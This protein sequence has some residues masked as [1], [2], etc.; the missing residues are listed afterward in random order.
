MK[1]KFVEDSIVQASDG[2]RQSLE[3]FGQ[4]IEELYKYPNQWAE[5][6]EPINHSATIYRLKERFKDIEV[7][8]RGG[9]N[10]AIDHPEKKAWTAYIRYVPDSTPI[11]EE[12][13]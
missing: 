7:A 5:Y 10:F 9:N 8:L 12:L 2:R 1:I 4:F 3:K 13:I 6:P 11:E